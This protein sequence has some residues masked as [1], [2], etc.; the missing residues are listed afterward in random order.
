MVVAVTYA[1]HS[2][3]ISRERCSTKHDSK[4]AGQLLPSIKESRFAEVSQEPS[5]P[6]R[7]QV[8]FH[9]IT[10]GPEYS[11]GKIGK[12]QI[13]KQ[14]EVLNNAFA[15]THFQFYLAADVDYQT[16]P[17]W[18]DIT[19]ESE[20]EVEEA[21][22]VKRKD[23]LNVY[24]A[25]LEGAYGWTV[26]PNEIQTY[27]YKGVMILFTTLPDGERYPYNLGHTLVH[28]IGHWL[29]LFHTFE[30]GCDSPGDNV[31]DTAPEASGSRA[32]EADRNT[33]SGDQ[34]P[35]PIDNF[36]DYSPDY[37][38]NKFTDNQVTLMNQTFAA[39]R[40]GP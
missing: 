39:Y 32:C 30:N 19:R 22:G 16:K 18:F 9:V 23:T 5:A 38:T 10:K 2:G 12:D 4:A 26:E 24:T 11:D 31:D 6:R 1:C 34:L 20:G 17:E 7:I 3:E 21:L 25:N 29:G 13:D 27:P 14:M 8:F 15:N 36:M 28:E 40:E 35:D 33:C 37:C